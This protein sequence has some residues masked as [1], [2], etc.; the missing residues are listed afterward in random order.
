MLLKLLSVLFMVLFSGQSFAQTD[1]EAPYLT[2]QKPVVGV[3]EREITYQHDFLSCERL[4]W[5]ACTAIG[6]EG[7]RLCYVKVPDAQKFIVTKNEFT[8]IDNNY[9]GNNCISSGRINKFACDRFADPQ[10]LPRMTCIV[11]QG[12]H[13]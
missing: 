4:K 7:I 10:E 8:V 13:D 12:Y 9:L 1:V 5:S 3:G 2:A 11:N 6:I